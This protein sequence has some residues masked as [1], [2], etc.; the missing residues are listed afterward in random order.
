MMTQQRM[1]HL[2]AVGCC[3]LAP[4]ARKRKRHDAAAGFATCVTAARPAVRRIE[5]RAVSTLPLLP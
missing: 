4:T 2:G 1:L 3:S 5:R